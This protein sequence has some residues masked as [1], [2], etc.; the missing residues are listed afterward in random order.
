M[1]S[2][3]WKNLLQFSFATICLNSCLF[4]KQ[5]IPSGVI[6]RTFSDPLWIFLGQFQPTINDLWCIF[7]ANTANGPLYYV[8][9]ACTIRFVHP[10]P[11]ISFTSCKLVFSSATFPLLS[12]T[13]QHSSHVLIL[14]SLWRANLSIKDIY[15]RLIKRNQPGDTAITAITLVKL[16][17]VI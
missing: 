2:T 15:K 9:P 11:G 8:N 14:F 4:S 13:T 5:C 1:I 3:S 7:E 16:I 17:L 12:V 10:F 6:W